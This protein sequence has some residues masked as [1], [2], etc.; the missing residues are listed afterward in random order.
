MT[1]TG[2]RR[3][4]LTLTATAALGAGGVVSLAATSHA[5]PAGV[6]RTL[7]T[8]AGEKLAFSTKRLSAPAGT[9]TLTLANRGDFDHDIAVRG[10]KLKAKKGPTVSTG[11]VSKVVVTLPPGTYTYFCT[12]FG[13]ESGGMR[14]TLTVTRR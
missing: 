14:G 12:V 3:V 9:I 7:S 8:A 1:A 5:K 2:I 6:T 10:K 13:H 4:A 11:E